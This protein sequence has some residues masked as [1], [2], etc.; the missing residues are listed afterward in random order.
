MS[1]ACLYLKCVTIYLGFDMK[2]WGG[3]AWLK[4]I[5]IENITFSPLL[6]IRVQISLFWS[7]IPAMDRFALRTLSS[8][9]MG[10]VAEPDP[11]GFEPFG[12]IRSNCPDPV[13]DPTIK[14]HKTLTK[15]ESN[16]LTRYIFKYNQQSLNKKQKIVNE[17]TQSK[18]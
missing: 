4:N 18:F 8:S 15:P 10:S 5:Y 2:W 3:G 17:T 16:K 6:T 14:S 9:N 13:P 7:R 12:R 1:L 11:V